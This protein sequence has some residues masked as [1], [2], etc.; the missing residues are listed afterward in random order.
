MPPAYEGMR[1][2]R[3]SPSVP[4]S[5]LVRYGPTAFPFSKAGVSVVQL[6]P[7]GR[8]RLRCAWDLRNAP[9]RRPGLGVDEKAQAVRLARVGVS[10]RAISRRMG[11]DRKDVRLDLIDA[12]LVVN[13]L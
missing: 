8:L 10:M 2:V 9:S 6:P 11:V 12:A 7:A 13:Q 1:R 3:E 5:V 4:P